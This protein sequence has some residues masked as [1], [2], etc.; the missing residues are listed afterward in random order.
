M[1]ELLRLQ[2][3]YNQEAN[4][5][6]IAVL[7]G[8]DENVLTK[9]MGLYYKSILGT[10]V[11]YSAGDASFFK[12]YFSS[13]CA[14]APS[15]SKIEAMLA[16]PFAF[17]P[18][19]ID[20]TSNLFAAREVLDSY[21]LDIVENINESDFKAIKTIHFPWGA[22]QKPVFQF[23]L[24]IL[25][26]ATHHRGMIACALDILKVDNDFNGMLGV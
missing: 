9:D 6:M 8:L 18:Q 11:H 16:E 26:H 2:G 15:S 24:A 1:K 23:I 4:K 13:F 21:I 25:N 14:K 19:I 3:R 12:D 20:D 10:M 5:K 22:M 17:K 7:E